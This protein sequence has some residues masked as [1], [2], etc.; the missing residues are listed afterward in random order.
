MGTPQ[1]P[2]RFECGIRVACSNHADASEALR[3]IAGMLA[4]EAIGFGLIYASSRY[5]ADD[6]AGG[7]SAHFAETPFAGCTTSGEIGRFGITEASIVVIG[8]PAADFTIASA[9]LPDLDQFGVEDGTRVV[10]RV[11]A[12]FPDL[13][14]GPV[15]APDEDEERRDSLF[16]LTLIDGLCKREEIVL[17]TLQRALGDVPVV[18]GSAGDDLAFERTHIF[19]DGQALSN[20]GVLLM[21]RTRHPVRLFKADNFEPTNLKFVVTECDAERR[22]VK[23]LDAEVAALTYAEAMGIEA[24]GLTPMSFAAHPVLV[25]VG[26]EYYCRSIQKLNPDGSLQFFCA[27]EN[28]VVLTAGRARDL[29]ESLEETLAGIDASLGGIDLV[30]GFDCVLRRLDAEHRQALRAMSDIYQRYRVFGFNTYGE[31]YKAMHL[32]QTFTGIAIGRSEGR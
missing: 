7:L 18:G 20:A 13:G 17:A 29:A 8:F 6:I 2:L 31:Q 26:G 1:A 23:E 16:A 32:N 15:I 9:L 4:G 11:L 24:G 19:H 3:D 10:R 28:G 25:K 30:L 12:S 21:V 22:I 5:R 27:I 14:E